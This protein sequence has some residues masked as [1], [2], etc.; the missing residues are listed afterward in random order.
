MFC[1]TAETYFASHNSAFLDFS[2]SKT[3][4]HWRKMRQLQMVLETC[5]P[6]LPGPYVLASFPVK[7]WKKEEACCQKYLL[8][9]HVYPV[10]PSFAIRETL[11]PAE[12]YV[13]VAKLLET[14]FTMWKNWE[15]LG[16]T[17]FRSKCFWQHVS[18]FC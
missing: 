3:G 16:K 10:F 18:S 11:F 7:P 8:Q 6:A 4:K 5:F 1:C 13:S 15:T 12:K 9:T 2:Y 14:M 17:C